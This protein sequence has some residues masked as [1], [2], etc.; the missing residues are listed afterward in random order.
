LA[1][2]IAGRVANVYDFHGPSFTIDA[3]CASSLAAIITGVQGLLLKEYDAV[4]CGGA[5]MSL[6]PWIF[7]SFSAIDALSPHGSFPF[8][9]RAN[10]FVMGQGAGT[11]VLKRLDDAIKN[12]NDI[13]SVITG[14]GETSDGKGKYIAAPNAEWQAKAVEN[15]CRMAGYPV[16]TIEL[17]EA[18][19]TATAVG[20]VVEVSGLKKGFSSM[21]ATK[22]NYCGLSSVKSNIGH[23][24]TAAGIAGFIKTALA[25]QHKVLPPTAN[26]E[27][28]NPKLEIEDSPFYILKEA[29]EWE[30]KKDHPRRANV[31]AFGFG[32]ANYHIAL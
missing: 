1:N 31:S 6:R 17:I 12:N 20:D 16:D 18:H 7:S 32:G 15:A 3:A 28:I 2:I 21:G 9:R 30:A 22:K 26:F 23:L 14:Y 24:K 5:D 13:I 25:L 27:E 11:V 8:D 29:R 19:G 10:G 4:V